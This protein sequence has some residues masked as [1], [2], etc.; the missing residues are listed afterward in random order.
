MYLLKSVLS[1]FPFCILFHILMVYQGRKA[2][3][4]FRAVHFVWAYLLILYTLW[5]FLSP[6]P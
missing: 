4:S 6:G 1:V 3:E 2:K 5:Y